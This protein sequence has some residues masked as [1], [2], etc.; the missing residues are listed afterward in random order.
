MPFQFLRKADPRQL[1]SFLQDEHPQ[2]IALVLAHMTAEQASRRCCPGL[3]PE[4]QAD[5]AH[6]I[7]MMDR[8]SPEVDPRRSRGAG[9]QAVL[10]AAARASCPPSAACSR[11]SRSS[12]A[13]TAA[14]ERLIL[15]GLE[16]RDP[17]LAEEVRARCSCSRTSS[18]ST[19]ARCS[20]CCARSRPTTSPPRSRAS[21]EEVRDKIM[22][23]L[24]E[25]AAE[26]LAEEIELLGPVRLAGRGGPGQGR[27]GHPHAS[28][29]P[30]SIIAS[31]RGD[32]DEFVA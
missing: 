1:L 12:T 21:R 20:W 14:T 28:R 26:N 29:S 11:W 32:D 9:A 15:E 22:Q 3:D 6:R 18:P 4:L 16:G 17:E 31:A 8:T 2:I 5:V 19:T 27:P 24:S 13:P 23:N 30:A 10:G 7:A 25:R